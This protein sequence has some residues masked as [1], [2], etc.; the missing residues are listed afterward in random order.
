MGCHISDTSSPILFPTSRRKGAKPLSL[1]GVLLAL[2]I[3]AACARTPTPTVS[4]V[5]LT[6]SGSSAMTPLLD[7]L[8][9]RFQQE[10]PSVVVTVDQRDSALGLAD[11]VSGRAA[12]GAVSAAPPE[13]MW[14]API[15]VDGIAII[16]HPDNSL[17]NLTM[18][19]LQDVF[20]GRVWHWHE[21]DVT[22]AGDEIQVVSREEGSGT[23]LSFEALAMRENLPILGDCPAPR[24]PD[25]G[26][27]IPPITPTPAPACA[28]SPVTSMAIV[29]MNSRATVEFVSQ[30]PGAI[31]YVSHSYLTSQAQARE[32]VSTVRIEGILPDPERTDPS[33][34]AT[35]G[36]RYP[37]TQPFFLVAP[38]EPDGAARLFVDFCLSPQGQA[39]VAAQ[40]VPVLR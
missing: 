10:H 19:Q 12:M 16:V 39:I 18:A 31:A 24:L 5:A 28:I 27:A 34:P 37:L 14:N 3:L 36:S 25:P 20:T 8:V 11:S 22:V 26:V 1:P 38:Q 35:A 6:I 2:V 21:L 13:S 7:R 33:A 15:A 4:P 23:R 30:N 9:A 29:V 32:V 17:A 40:A